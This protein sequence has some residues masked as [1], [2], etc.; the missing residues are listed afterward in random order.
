M[1]VYVIGAICVTAL[2]LAMAALFIVRASLPQ[3]DGERVER[4]LGAV[5]RMERDALGVV[6]L[7]GTSRDDLA[8]ATGFVHAQDRFFDILS[9]LKDGDSYRA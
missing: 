9:A 3:L 1:L 7:S 8:Y 5:V 4:S 2:A 6:S